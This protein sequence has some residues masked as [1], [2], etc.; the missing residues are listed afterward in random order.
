MPDEVDDDHKN[1]RFSPTEFMR[2][3]RPYLFSDTKEVEASDLTRDVFAY[4]LETLT[5]QKDETLF[6]HFA[7]RLAQKFIAPNIRPQTGPRL[8]GME[9]AT[10]RRIQWRVK[11]LRAG[12]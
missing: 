7:Q 1:R 4:H 10:L 11:Y 3:R 9:R 8:V 5:K 2:G 12:S 6:E